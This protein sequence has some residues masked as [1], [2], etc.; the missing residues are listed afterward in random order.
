[1]KKILR[2]IILLTALLAGCRYVIPNLNLDTSAILE[3]IFEWIDSEALQKIGKEGLDALTEQF[4]VLEPFLSER[5]ME[6]LMTGEGLEELEQ[7]ASDHRGLAEDQ[8][9]NVKT[10]LDQMSP[11]LSDAV[12]SVLGDSSDLKD[13]LNG[14]S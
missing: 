7:Y 8:L 13:L 9:D 10:I 12:D 11:E 6:D 14:I 3:T 1:M 2:S 5:G 4:P